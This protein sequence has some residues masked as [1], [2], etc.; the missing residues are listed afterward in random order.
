VIYE[1]VKYSPGYL[2]CPIQD[3]AQTLAVSVILFKS[4]ENQA[5]FSTI[6]LTFPTEYECLEGQR[7]PSLY[8]L[9]QTHTDLRLSKPY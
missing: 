3:Q 5:T 2:L 6:L 7:H 4:K 9:F 8:L 1:A